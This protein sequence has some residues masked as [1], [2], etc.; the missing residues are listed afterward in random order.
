MKTG[1][2]D[3]FQSHFLDEIFS[4]YKNLRSEAAKTAALQAKLS[5]TLKQW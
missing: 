2:K 1:I 4:S 3:T 5:Q